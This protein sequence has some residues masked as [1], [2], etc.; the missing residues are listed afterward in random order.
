MDILFAE[1]SA[2]IEQAADLEELD[3]LLLLMKTKLAL[4]IVVEGHTDKA[5]SEKHNLDLS[6]GRA[7]SV[8]E[9]LVQKGIDSSR[10]ET[11]GN[12]W[13]TPAYPY[14]DAEKE[15][16]LN[17]RIEVKIAYYS[18]KNAQEILNSESFGRLERSK[19]GHS[20]SKAYSPSSSI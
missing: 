1:A 6:L 3:Q 20:I 2:K 15:N 9:Y 12:G 16:P 14:Q 8:K 5:G 7:N 4:R 11:K 13:S 18:K 19:E 17:R 10:I